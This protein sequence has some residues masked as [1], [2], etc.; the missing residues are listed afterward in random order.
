MAVQFE[1][2]QIIDIAVMRF[3]KILFSLG[4]SNHRIE[5]YND[6]LAEVP[7][8]N[9]FLKLER[10]SEQNS[11]GGGLLSYMLRSSIKQLV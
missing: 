10:A 3:Y 9:H 6:R 2:T 11:P 7:F 4:E 5:F 8:Y 1:Y